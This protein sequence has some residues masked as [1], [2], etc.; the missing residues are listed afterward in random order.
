M[1]MTR[2]TK[3]AKPTNAPPNPLS[4]TAPTTA[5]QARQRQD[6]ECA[7]P[8]PAP[9][10]SVRDPL[11]VARG[12][13]RLVK[14]PGRCRLARK[15]MR[16]AHF[17]GKP[18]PATVADRVFDLAADMVWAAVDKVQAA[19]KGR[20][21][22]RRIGRIEW[23]VVITAGWRFRIDVGA[24]VLVRRRTDLAR[25]ASD[26]LR[27][28]PP[29]ASPLSPQ[30][31]SAF[32]TKSGSSGLVSYLLFF[33]FHHKVLRFARANGSILLGRN[34]ILNLFPTLVPLGNAKS[35]QHRLPSGQANN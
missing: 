4:V 9:R 2:K 30:A 28:G 35:A 32:L 19:N 29:A 13:T 10:E 1:D 5:K 34:C 31:W 27:S 7:K 23:N 16:M 3:A 11:F 17:S 25:C 8:S 12:T 22:N 15:A 21:K 14:T 26:F 33:G 20:N 18:M 6:Q 24:S